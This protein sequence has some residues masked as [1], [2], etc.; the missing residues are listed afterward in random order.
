MITLPDDF[1]KPRYNEACFADLPPTILALLTGQGKPPLAPEMLAGLSSR[2]ERV[3]C[4]FVDALGWRFVQ[5]H[6]ADYPALQ[7]LSRDGRLNQ[8]TAQ[9]PSTTAA[10]VTCIHT[11]LSVG[12]SGVYEWQYYEPHLDAV[13]SPLLFSFAGTR[14]RD[15]LKPTG[16]DPRRL[17]PRQNLYR[18][19]RAY[20]IPATLFQHEAYAHSTYSDIVG[21]GAEVVPFRTISEGLVNLR[22]RVSRQA[23]PGYFFLYFDQIDAIGHK[24]GPPAIQFAAEMDTFLVALERLFLRPLQGRL[25][26]TLLLLIA[27]HGLAEID[28]QRTIYLNTDPTFA[29]L[30]RYL[31]TDRAGELLPP[32]GSPRDLF[33]YVKD[34]HLTEAHAF[35]AERLAD[36]A[37]VYPTRHLI[38]AGFF[39]PVPAESPLWA[40]LAGL[41][42]LPLAG[43]AVWWYEKDKFEQKFYG[44]HGGLT[45]AE[46][47]TP[48]FVY[49]F[50][51]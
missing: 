21:D 2:Y 15:T 33:L 11:G 43:Q 47:E 23:G 25:K 40:R 5:Q 8:M 26:D 37:V 6:L 29:G 36:Q 42:I 13:I 34:E 32:G 31:R 44:H 46:M 41:V 39:G 48:L 30:Q 3:I 38:E 22:Q 7:I 49:D 35:L 50:P 17:Y 14:E 19:L 18:Q 24:Y 12:R 16:I 4:L 28:P 9:F 45:R 10:H 1:I 20:D 27:D 51:G